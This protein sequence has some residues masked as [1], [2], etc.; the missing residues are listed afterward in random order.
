MS[1]TLGIDGGATATKWALRK[2]D[3]TFIEG[4]SGPIDGH[5]YRSESK[6][7]LENRI[8]VL[9][10]PDSVRTVLAQEIKASELKPSASMSIPVGFTD[11]DEQIRNLQ[12][13]EKY[14]DD[15]PK[16]YI[17]CANNE[18]AEKISKYLNNNNLPNGDYCFSSKEENSH[19]SI[20]CL[21]D[22]ERNKL[23]LASTPADGIWVSPLR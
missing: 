22:K 21:W 2:A 8:A 23:L 20:I 10:N 15:E 17:N 14:L 16:I 1:Y 19:N 3:G 12:L 6:E 7:R 4:N 18:T 11:L 5:I 9:N 13:L